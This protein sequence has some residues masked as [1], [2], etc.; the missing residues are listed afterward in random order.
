MEET[1]L[2][3][4]AR[5]RAHSAESEAHSAERKLKQAVHKF[6]RKTVSSTQTLRKDTD[7]ER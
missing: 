3:H 6:G 1:W 2:K 4:V 5:V 7:M